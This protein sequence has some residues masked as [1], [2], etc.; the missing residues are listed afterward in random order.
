M[1]HGLDTDVGSCNLRFPIELDRP[2]FNES[3]TKLKGGD[4]VSHCH[5]P[6]LPAGPTWILASGGVRVS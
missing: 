2:K 3:L 1:A 4:P 5:S 6:R